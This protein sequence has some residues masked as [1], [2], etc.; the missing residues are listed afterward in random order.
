MNGSTSAPFRRCWIRSST[1]PKR[2][3]ERLGLRPLISV[4]T[5]FLDGQDVMD[6]WMHRP[7]FIERHQNELEDYKDTL[8]EEEF[9][10]HSPEVH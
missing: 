1:R 2:E 8:F 6:W 9:D 10:G 7:A 3:R 4:S 5:P